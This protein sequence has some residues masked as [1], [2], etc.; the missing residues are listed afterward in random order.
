MND[1]NVTM[2]FSR[3]APAIMAP[4]IERPYLELLHSTEY[5]GSCIISLKSTFQRP[6]GGTLP[7]LYSMSWGVIV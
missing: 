6:L 5:L 3:F 2:V 1:D 4:Q 7:L